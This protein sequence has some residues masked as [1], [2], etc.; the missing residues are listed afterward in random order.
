[1]HRLCGVESSS[2]EELVCWSASAAPAEVPATALA[3]LHAAADLVVNRFEARSPRG[4][5]QAV[6][7]NMTDKEAVEPL[8]PEAEQLG[9]KGRER[10]VIR[11]ADHDERKVLL[12]K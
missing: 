5:G 10:T 1:M 11:D 12:V 2:L 9:G 4:G 6:G 8:V 7:R 3:C